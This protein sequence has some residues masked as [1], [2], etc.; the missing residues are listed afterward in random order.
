[1]AREYLISKYEENER[2]RSWNAIFQSI[3]N[4]SDKQERALKL[5]T[6]I[7][8]SWQNAEKNRYRNVSTYDCNRVLLKR[9]G[10][11][12]SDYINASPVVVP[13]AKRNYILTQGPLSST[14]NDFW[15]M[16]WEQECA[17]I[18]MLNRVVEKNSVKC[19]EYF[20]T[21]N[22]K[23]LIYDTFQVSLI[24][25]EHFEHYIVR[26][27][28]LHAK[29]A[30]MLEGGSG[31][32]TRTVLHFQ[33]VSWPDFGVP[34]CSKVFLE[35]LYRVRATG[36]L[37]KSAP[38]I[39][40]C[41]AGIGRSGTFV[42]V[43]SVLSMISEKVSNVD[44]ED[45]VVKM[46]RNRM[47]LIQTPQQ[48]QFCWKSIAD[49]LRSNTNNTDKQGTPEEEAKVPNANAPEIVDSGKVEVPHLERS[50]ANQMTSGLHAKSL[51]DLSTI[52]KRSSGEAFETEE[53]AKHARSDSGGNG[54][55]RC[56]RVYGKA[57]VLRRRVLVFHSPPGPSD[58]PVPQLQLQL[59]QSTSTVCV[60]EQPNE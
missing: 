13:Q 31:D 46:R 30:R 38:V 50:A 44:L 54:S 35:F 25:E 2:N 58:T 15:Q 42:V 29:D 12:Q 21:E 28:E 43:D 20:P 24:L 18:V 41:S 52:R 36:F 14:S 53:D 5:S 34:H 49:A 16:V 40:H 48:L 22:N 1:M 10:D 39:V 45:L 27:I 8:H 26:T 37:E 60:P 7:A 33:F 17:L 3:E 59:S 47:G 9:T 19:H 56:G 11:D 4:M 57:N 55:R 6:R 32:S 23:E 51:T